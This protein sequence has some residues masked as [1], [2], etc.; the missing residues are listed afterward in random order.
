MG[1]GADVA[2]EAIREHARIKDVK[3]WQI[4][5]SLGIGDTTL[6][7]RMRHEIPEDRKQEILDAIDR[8]ADER[9]A[10]AV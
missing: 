10:A 1:K 4:A 6:C 8:I 9:K 5:E 7:R 2:N 3:M